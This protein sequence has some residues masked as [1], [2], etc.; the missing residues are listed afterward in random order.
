MTKMIHHIMLCI[1]RIAFPG[2]WVFESLC[3]IF[4]IC[5]LGRKRFQNAFMAISAMGHLADICHHGV[6]TMDSVFTCDP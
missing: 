4:L 3:I 5:T 6:W 2:S 1:M